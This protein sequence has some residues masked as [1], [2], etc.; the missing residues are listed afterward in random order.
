MREVISLSQTHSNGQAAVS[1]GG[2]CPKAIVSDFYVMLKFKLFDRLK[3]ARITQIE[4]IDI[5]GLVLD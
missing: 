1:L 5:L 2:I 3:L 4:T